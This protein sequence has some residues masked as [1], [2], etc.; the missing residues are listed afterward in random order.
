[1]PG[2]YRFTCRSCGAD[3]VVDEFVRSS[4]EEEG[5]PICLAEPAAVHLEPAE[6]AEQR[7]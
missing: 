6:D 4:L 3:V 7:A 2:H 1:M 5:C